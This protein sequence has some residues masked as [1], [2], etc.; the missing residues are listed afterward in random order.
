LKKELIPYIDGVEFNRGA[1]TLYN[2]TVYAGSI[3]GLYVIDCYHVVKSFLPVYFNKIKADKTE[4]IK[5][6]VFYGTGLI[7]LLTGLGFGYQAY[8]RKKARFIVPQKEEAPSLT[9]DQIAEAIRTH[10]IMT[11]EGLAEFYK[12]NTVQLN[13]QFKTFDTTPGK[14]MKTVKI[15]YARELLKNKVPM[16]EVSAKLGYSASF[17][18]KELKEMGF[19]PGRS[20][21]NH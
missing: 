11:V 14:F 10:N 9:I 16:A 20:S 19:N 12:T 6:W 2:D 3:S 21:T 7:I 4:Q 8:K 13:R 18:K 15:N 17:I 5:I 1:L